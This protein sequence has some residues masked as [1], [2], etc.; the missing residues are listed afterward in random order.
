MTA[1]VCVVIL[2]KARAMSRS[3]NGKLHVYGLSLR[4]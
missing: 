4:M 1:G 2:Y 3:K